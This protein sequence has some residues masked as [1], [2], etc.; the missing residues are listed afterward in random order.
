MI[1]RFFSTTK[2]SV[3]FYYDVL[4][5]TSDATQK[6]I[7]NA[8]YQ[9][10][11]QHHPDVSTKESHTLFTTISEAYQTLT[12]L[13][14]KRLYDERIRQHNMWNEPS[15]DVDV[16]V[17]KNN[18]HYGR[19]RNFR[20]RTNTRVKQDFDDHVQQ[21]PS[22]FYRSKMSK[23]A[24]EEFDAFVNQLNAYRLRHALIRKDE[25]PTTSKNK[26]VN[27][28]YNETVFEGDVKK[29]E[30]TFVFLVW[31]VVFSFFGMV[32]VYERGENN[33]SNKETRQVYKR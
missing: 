9:K 12:D 4:G 15:V 8:Y 14:Q 22:E 13:D 30:R 10:S 32:V 33:E 29:D 21:E 16:D 7:K 31:L 23:S 27:T 28:H 25:K 19:R 20:K 3:T 1:K 18:W 24:E 5:I 6:Q 26:K 2:K 11:K 17:K